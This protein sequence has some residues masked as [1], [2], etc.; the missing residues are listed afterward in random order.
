MKPTVKNRFFLFALFSIA[1]LAGCSN[2]LNFKVEYQDGQG[3]KKGDSVVYGDEKIGAVSDVNYTDQGKIRVDVVVL[4]KYRNLARQSALFYISDS[5][6]TDAKVIE[7]VTGQSD[8]AEQALPIAEGQI[9]QGNTR[10][11][12]LTQKLQNRFGQALQ[13]FSE[14][15]QNQWQEWKSG[16]IDKQVD[17]LEKGLDRILKDIE[18]LG[19]NTRDQIKTE[20]L[21]MI[22]RQIEALRRHLEE[23]GREKDIDS[24]DKKMEEIKGYIEA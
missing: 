7:L 15:M 3:L 23:L 11:S 18:N 17:Q 20:L 10:V 12:G 6:G 24:I 1:V 13:S 16:T 4:E 19:K 9:I 22:N 14:D 21:P 2:D 8:Q 5:K